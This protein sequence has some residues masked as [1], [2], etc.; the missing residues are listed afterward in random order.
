MTRLR[1]GWL[2]PIAVMVVTA[3]ACTTQNSH[4]P[5]TTTGPSQQST[6]AQSAT[7]ARPTLTASSLQ[8]PPQPSKYIKP[9]R[10]EVVF[11]PCT[12]IPD[13]AIAK[14]GYDPQSRARGGDQIAEQIFLICHFDSRLRNLS[15]LSGN[16]SWDEDLK[17]NGAWSEPITINGRQAMWVRDPGIKFGCDIHL[18]TKVGF[19]DVGPV[20]TI[21]GR[22][23]SLNPCDG[24]LET[25]TAIEPSIGKD[26]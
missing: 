19:V 3:T 22:G 25:A 15:V 8:P 13:D 26:N 4:D 2:M 11:D 1:H 23:E 14:S 12:W 10:A 21:Y 9:G 5:N 6:S 16:V 17:K 20:L 18:R 24:V 7:P